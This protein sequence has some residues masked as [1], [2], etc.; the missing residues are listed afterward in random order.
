[1]ES[2]RKIWEPI[3]VQKQWLVT[4]W[5]L[6]Q[7]YKQ[8][9]CRLSQIPFWTLIQCW[10]FWSSQTCLLQIFVRWF[11]LENDCGQ[12]C[13]IQQIIMQI[14]II[15]IF[16]VSIVIRSKVPCLLNTFASN[17]FL[18]PKYKS[19][20]TTNRVSFTGITTIVQKENKIYWNEFDNKQI[21]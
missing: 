14:C 19:S 15:W 1:M 3:W 2:M 20:T 4:Q 9:P 5:S 16:H 18:M 7:L 10:N 8:H 17:T 12:S 11:D 21:K 6:I 13:P